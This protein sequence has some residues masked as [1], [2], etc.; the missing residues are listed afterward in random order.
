MVSRKGA[1]V[2]NCTAE[3]RIGSRLTQPLLEL[4]KGQFTIGTFVAFAFCRGAPGIEY[5]W[6]YLPG[7]DPVEPF[8]VFPAELLENFVR[9]FLLRPALHSADFLAGASVLV[10]REGAELRCVAPRDSKILSAVGADAHTLFALDA[11]SDGELYEVI[12]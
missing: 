9:V 7:L 12:D 8:L 2:K 11:L 6:A 10:H 3:Q 1:G 5:A 4:F